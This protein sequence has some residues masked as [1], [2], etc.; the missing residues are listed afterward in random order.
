MKIA[1]IGGGPSGLYFALLTKKRFPAADI[2]V[3]EQNPRGATFG[4]GI[5]LADRGLGRM[6][7]A[8]EESATAIL[9][10]CFMTQHQLITHRG[11]SIFV[12]RDAFGGAI[13]RL[14]LLEVLEG[15]CSKYN[16]PVHFEARIDD[17][18]RFNDCDLIVGA[19]GV[20]SSVRRAHEAEF[21]TTSW[22]LTN[23]LAWYGTT[24]HFSHPIITFKHTELG[25]F[26]AV[27]YPY[28]ETMGTFVAECDE[29]TWN[30]SGIAQ[31]DDAGRTKLTETLFADELQGHALISNNS[32]WRS[33]PVIRNRHWSVGNCVLIGDALH[34][35]HPS[36]GSGTRIAMEDAIDLAEALKNRQGNVA[37]A[38]T[39]FESVR[40]PSKQK[41]V[42]AAE[43]S[44][45]WYEDIACKMDALA[46]VPFVF[47]YLT[48][49]GRVNE[50]RLFEE[51]PRL[52][53]KYNAEWRVF[54][55][56]RIPAAT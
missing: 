49:T 51:F 39:E 53:E 19:D 5:I 20:N 2:Q 8:D 1:V 41:M 29:E 35:A 18:S 23:R 54:R 15:C 4:F 45:M 34:S 11:E 47:D 27:A 48:R 37:E 7:R 25:R 43:K 31:M 55:D 16:I 21:G 30:K 42:D 3:Y 40:K 9:D 12:E 32:L 26:W 52:M 17:L 6:Q 46:P 33:L 50:Q 14:R 38:L 24:Q 22:N 28:T 10:A 56:E 36:I 13:A 44:F